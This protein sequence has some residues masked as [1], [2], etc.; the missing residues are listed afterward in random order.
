MKRAVFIGTGNMGGALAR[1]AVQALGGEQVAVASRTFERAESLARELA[2]QVC[3]TNREAAQMGEYIFL[4]V[5]PA[6]MRKVVEELAPELTGDQT[7]VS[8]AA[9]VTLHDL[10]S[11]TGGRIPI[12]RIMPNTPCMIG[13]GMT[14]LTGGKDVRE[15]HFADVE[16]ILACS[17][18]VER[19]EEAQIDAFSAVAGCGPA[20]IYPY[21]EALA[22]GGVAAGLPRGKALIYAAQMTLGA[23]AMVLETGEHPDVYKRQ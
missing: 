12:L 19:V 16:A 7:L 14:A 9:G 20:F 22:D 13:M 17:G 2:C 3:T 6:Q 11:W 10:Q 15:K 4:C 21:I 5:K 18:R 23:A 8:I 1:A